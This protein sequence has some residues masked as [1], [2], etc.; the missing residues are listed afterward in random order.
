MSAA[1]AVKLVVSSGIHR[2]VDA[3][4]VC[5]AAHS[6]PGAARVSPAV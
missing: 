4:R 6:V 5:L 1:N 2:V 3:V